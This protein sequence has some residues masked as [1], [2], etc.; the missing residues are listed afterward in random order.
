MGGTLDQ[1]QGDAQASSAV[2]PLPRDRGERASE[3]P[4][5]LTAGVVAHNEEAHLE[6]AVRSLLEQRL[7]PNVRWDRLWVVASG[8]TDRTTEIAHRLALADPRVGVVVEADRGGKARAL[9]EVLRRATGSAVVL[10]NG[11]AEATPGSLSE[12]IRAAR[13][14]PHG[15]PTAVMGRP[16]PRPNGASPRW[17]GVIDLMW[18][19]HHRFHE[20]LEAVGG[21]AHLSDELLLLTLPLPVDLP[22]GTI[23]DGSYLGVS[24][25]GQ[26]AARH[27]AHGAR[28]TTEAPSSIRDHL[29]QRRRIR[30][31][32]LEVR[33][34]LGRSPTSIVGSALA[35]P[36]WGLRFAREAVRD[37]PRGLRGLLTLA[38]L[39][40][41][42]YLLAA[43]DQASRRHDH[44]R[45][46]RVRRS[47]PGDPDPREAAGVRPPDRPAPNP[48][49]ERIRVLTE[50]AASFGTSR[51]LSELVLLLPPGGPRT[52]DELR[53]WLDGHPDL[54][55][56]DGDR[57]RAPRTPP[58]DDQRRR[59]LG[60]DYLRFARSVWDGPLAAARP[61]VECVA[62]SGSAAYGAPEPGDD[63][64]FFV[65]TRRGALWWFLAFSYLADRR[66]RRGRPT[67]R[68]PP[69]CLNYVMDEARARAMYDA[70][71][72]LFFAREALTLR[73]VLGEPFYRGL[74]AEAPWMAAH[75]PTLYAER[76]GD[77]RPSPGGRPA[78]FGIRLM[79]AALGPWVAAYLQLVGLRR[80]ARFRRSAE[81]DR[82]F[83]THTSWGRM[84]ITSD[85]FERL[86]MV[87]E[88]GAAVRSPSPSRSAAE[89]S[90][91]SP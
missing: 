15:T 8:C 18:S 79:N 7:P 29:A 88:P 67:H 78:P 32:N 46:A 51:P 17:T 40:S 1:R 86:R 58:V 87:Y 47:L 22:D 61:W 28:V 64:D 3:R 21:G 5:T 69:L 62:L 53:A 66:F 23:N 31:G 82:G 35:R 39:E 26:G 77:Q 75:L 45:W 12:L 14:E 43:W 49:G 56:V 90:T 63:L 76:V 19:L 11:D 10:L 85:R 89:P 24:L 37:R 50:L 81:V 36:S 48:V 68:G 52:V 42:A 4:W 25:A 74:L 71:Q 84:Q 2:D 44:V 65:V 27:Y 60:A 54:A 91:P 59:L 80:N 33:R 72:G 83:R 73:T 55:V 16:V 9:R 20:Q 70:D 41:F 57:V 30:F 34:L 38:A 6:Q 13:S